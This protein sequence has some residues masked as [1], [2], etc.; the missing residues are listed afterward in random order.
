MCCLSWIST[1]DDTN[2]YKHHHL[3]EWN[4]NCCICAVNFGCSF[5]Q[6]SYRNVLR[7]ERWL[8]TIIVINSLIAL[9]I[10]NI[11]WAVFLCKSVGK[12]LADRE[13]HRCKSKKIHWNNSILN[14]IILSVKV[15]KLEWFL[16][17]NQFLVGNNRPK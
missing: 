14:S 13:I 6:H 5:T 4:Q 11:S 8:N 12:N 10:Y 15:H 9:V 7:L 2:I 1:K 3:N 16:M 17:N